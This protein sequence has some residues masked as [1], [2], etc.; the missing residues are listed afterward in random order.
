MKSACFEVS[1]C[2]G[3]QKNKVVETFASIKEAREFAKK[4]NL[5]TAWGLGC[6]FKEYKDKSEGREGWNWAGKL[7]D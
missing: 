4:R 3:N 5:Q 7:E 2:V 6:S 1:G